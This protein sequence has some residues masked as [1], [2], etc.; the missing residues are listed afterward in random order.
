[1]TKLPPSASG[2]S[3]FTIPTTNQPIMHNQNTNAQNTQSSIQP[4]I[5]PNNQVQSQTNTLNTQ[6]Q[7]VPNN[8]KVNVPLPNQSP[9]N[10]YGIGQPVAPLKNDPYVH[11]GDNASPSPTTKPKG[12]LGVHKKQ[13]QPQ[14]LE[15]PTVDQ[16][17][18]PSESPK[19]QLPPIGSQEIQIPATQQSQPQKPVT[20]TIQEVTPNTVNNYTFH[21]TGAQAQ[22]NIYHSDVETSNNKNASDNNTNPDSQ[23]SKPLSIEDINEYLMTQVL[24]GTSEAQHNV[25]EM[26]TGVQEV[27]NAQTILQKAQERFKK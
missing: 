24:N 20:T 19:I 4:N 3:A 15:P 23:T 27:L 18:S 17:P 7:L 22:I 25:K 9:A 14:V 16:A 8:P 11:S 5:Q 1:M 6:S 2:R 12:L 26:L 13:N 21:I 10:K